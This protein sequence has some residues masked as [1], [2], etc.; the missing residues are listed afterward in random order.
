MAKKI[1]S[2]DLFEQED[3]FKGIKES[4]TE[5]INKLEQLEM[6]LKGIAQSTEPLIKNANF[7][8]TKGIKEF[9]TATQKA[10]AVSKEFLAVEKEKQSLRKAQA[11]AE[12][13]PNVA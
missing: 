6:S 1:S 10:E 4:A 11:Q 7:G 3:I 8:T 13:K 5:A 9:T 2:S 12:R